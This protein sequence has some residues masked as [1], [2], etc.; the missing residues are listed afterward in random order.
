MREDTFLR[1]I[2]CL[3]QCHLANSEVQSVFSWQ[4]PVRL[5]D[6]FEIHAHIADFVPVILY[7]FIFS[8]ILVLAL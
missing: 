2:L 8:L 6:P 3:K 7:Y 4:D 5:L 1:C